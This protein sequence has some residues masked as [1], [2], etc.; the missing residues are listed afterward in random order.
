MRSAQRPAKTE[1]TSVAT[2]P[3]PMTVPARTPRSRRQPAH[4][5]AGNSRRRP[6]PA[7][8][9]PT[10]MAEGCAWAADPPTAF[11]HPGALRNDGSR[12]GTK[13]SWMA[14]QREDRR[15]AAIIPLR[16][17]LRRAASR[18]PDARFLAPLREPCGPG[19][20]VPRQPLRCRN[21]H[22]FQHGQLIGRFGDPVFDA[23]H[24]PRSSNS[25]RLSRCRHRDRSPGP[26]GRSRD[27]RKA[28]PAGGSC[29]RYRSRPAAA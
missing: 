10:D 6:A 3:T 14:A 17:Q 5:P 16:R 28:S 21:Q 25:Q 2:M 9:R 15:G 13:R 8:W 7:T 19:A 20:A 23:V 11:P 22:L 29:R 1:P 27:R 12:N 18:R 4:P 26:W 24:A